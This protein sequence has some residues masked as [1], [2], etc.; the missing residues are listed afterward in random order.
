MRAR[1]WIENAVSRGRVRP[2]RKFRTAPPPGGFRIERRRA[3]STKL[4]DAR[5][6]LVPSSR[7]FPLREDRQLRPKG[8]FDAK[9]DRDGLRRSRA[10]PAPCCAGTRELAEGARR[11]EYKRPLR[12][13]RSCRG[14]LALSPHQ[15]EQN[16]KCGARV[17]FTLYFNL[18]AMFLNDSVHDGQ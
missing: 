5:F 6:E 17:Q 2:R 10:A 12:V 8:R 11:L 15:R 1:A 3:R 18:P 16:V 4:R 7:G 14:H 13:R 9:P